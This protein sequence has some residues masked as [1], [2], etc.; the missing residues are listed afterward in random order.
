[1]NLLLAER[2]KVDEKSL[3]SRGTAAVAQNEVDS[4]IVRATEQ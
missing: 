2:W 3:H 1:M 4:Q